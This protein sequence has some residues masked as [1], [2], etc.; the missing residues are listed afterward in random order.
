MSNFF[1]AQAWPQANKLRS[2]FQHI[3]YRRIG[4][5]TAISDF[6]L[7]VVASLGGEL[8]YHYPVD[9]APGDVPTSIAI[10]AYSGLI[11]VLLSRLL[12][13]YQP[14]ALLSAST[15]VRGVAFAWGGV[16]LTVTSFFFLLK[17]GEHFSRGGTIAFGILGVAILF[18]SRALTGLNLKR[19]LANSTLAGQRS[20]VIGEAE[21]LTI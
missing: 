1:L 17:N 11:F 16:L 18:A 10:G 9:G 8:L 7:V 21:E 14:N 2:I 15:Q 3:P 4:I 5:F 6:T 13:L 12:G 19:A 20:I